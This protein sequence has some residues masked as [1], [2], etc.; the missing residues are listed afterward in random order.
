MRSI[1]NAVRRG[2][3]FHFRR[4]VPTDIRAILGRREL[5]RSLDTSDARDARIR[6]R[7]LYIVSETLF[8][9]V[10]TLP[11][12]MLTTDKLAKLVQTFYETVLLEENKK[13]LLQGVISAEQRQTEI[14]RHAAWAADCKDALARNDL[15]FMASATE[16]M[17]LKT[18]MFGIFTEEDLAHVRQSMLRAGIELAEAIK[19]R[20]EGD[21]N[22]EPRDKLLT[23][24]I[25]QVQTQASAQPTPSAASVHFPRKPVPPAPPASKA[26]MFSE[27][28]EKFRLQQRREG[29]WRGQ[30]TQ[31][32]R[33]TYELF[34]EI[35]GPWA[36][37]WSS[38]PAFMAHRRLT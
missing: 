31:Q 27:F 19:A 5:T 25:Q 13:R 12:A 18:R 30:H 17:L 15:Q 4:A 38:S 6:A 33:K 35:A 21:F 37:R 26:P 24:V 36:I 8:D 14:E 16:A 9:T 3:T 10:R 32:S 29:T 2:N 11:I 22:Y 34:M 23:Q 20:Y 1:P 7:Q 28:A